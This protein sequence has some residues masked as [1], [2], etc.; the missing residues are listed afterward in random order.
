ME[1]T[2]LEGLE[3]AISGEEVAVTRSIAKRSRVEVAPELE[4]VNSSTS[5]HKKA[6]K[7]SL[8]STATSTRS[9][10][11]VPVLSDPKGVPRASSK[12]SSLVASPSL[13]KARA[14]ERS[15]ES[16]GSFSSQEEAEFPENY[17]SVSSISSSRK[18][19][20][21][22]EDLA[23]FP[24]DT[25]SSDWREVY[26]MREEWAS[27]H[28]VASA[29]LLQQRRDEDRARSVASERVSNDQRSS[30]VREE[31][32]FVANNKS[33]H[34]VVTSQAPVLEFV[35]ATNMKEFAKQV[36]RYLA[37]GNGRN[38]AHPSSLLTESA[39]DMLIL[40]WN[41][42]VKETGFNCSFEQAKSLTPEDWLT[43]MEEAVCSLTSTSTKPE[44]LI[45]K[46]LR[47]VDKWGEACMKMIRQKSF[48]TPDQLCATY[49]KGLELFPGIKV[50]VE[51]VMAQMSRSLNRSATP[52][53]CLTLCLKYSN[54]TRS[55]TNQ[56]KP[57]KEK[58]DV[59]E[60]EHEVT[61][62]ANPNSN[63]KPKPL[64]FKGKGKGEEKDKGKLADKRELS[65]VKCYACNK[66]G[67]YANACTEKEP[68]GKGK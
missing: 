31:D 47:D 36:R 65:K 55:L 49:L 41:D 63:P 68:A 66:M 5:V 40:H 1:G 51:N 52:G 48:L 50:K 61:P 35:S 16:L 20:P 44:D 56:D 4:I 12:V 26:R 13:G 23:P 54:L 22:R 34:I 45:L 14:G 10:H 24:S 27:S 59:P 30:L 17:R 67:H 62:K 7:E 64:P 2:C 32:T 42:M 43:R 33:P 46:S 21:V 58:P 38:V 37:N 18:D 39:G 29:M 57:F 9:R 6:R 53:E 60:K 15:R 3:A 8:L 25:V 19:F 11:A 28:P